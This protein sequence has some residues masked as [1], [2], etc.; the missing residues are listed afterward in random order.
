MLDRDDAVAFQR[1]DMKGSSAGA[2][3]SAVVGR[4]PQ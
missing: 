3:A 1:A 4:I 2:A